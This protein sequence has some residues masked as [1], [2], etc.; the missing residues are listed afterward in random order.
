MTTAAPSTAQ[1]A[2][3]ARRISGNRTLPDR[4]ALTTARISALKTARGER[5]RYVW[6]TKRAGLGVRVM[7]TG[8]KSFVWYGKV[9]GKP[10]R[11]T[12]GSCSAISLDAARTR[13]QSIWAEVSAGLDPAEEKIKRAA[14]QYTVGQCLD[15]WLAYAAGRKRTAREDAALVRLHIP[16]RLR[17]RAVRTITTS[18]IESLANA[19]A[20]RGDCRYS[21]QRTA[22]KVLALLSSA[23]RRAEKHKLMDSNPVTGAS[24]FP[25][26]ERDR[27]I[28]PDEMPQFWA[29]LKAQPE[30]WRSYFT[31][32]LATG[33]RRGA[34]AAMRWKDIDMTSAVWHLPASDSKTAKALTIALSPIALDALQSMR[35]MSAGHK[36]VF[37]SASQT[38]H[39]VEPRKPWLRLCRAAGINDLRMH[40]VRRTLGSWLTANG[41]R[42]N[43][44]R[45]EPFHLRIFVGDEVY[46]IT[47]APTGT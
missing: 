33:A 23:F 13:A 1:P 16:A 10:R 4:A 34:V 14:A 44:P 46:E 7:A 26:V 3:P 37:P 29:A 19:I 45:S 25:T 41:A 24:R 47:T 18:D 8:A 15:D 22:N 28:R 11:V 5:L 32:L 30:P 21:R 42:E 20:A 17:A 31:L 27:F 43:L 6:D 39:I 35:L 12:I 2:A 40:D 9:H 36:F 38:G